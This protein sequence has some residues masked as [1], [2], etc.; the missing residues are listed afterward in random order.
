MTGSTNLEFVK[1]LACMAWA[2]TEVTHDEL[3][4]IKR[5]AR[6][7]DLSGDEWNELRMY[8]EEPVDAREMQRVTRRFLA[9]VRGSKHKRALLQAVEQL[10]RSKAEF[11]DR[12][13]EWLGDLK[14]I[15]AESGGGAFLVDGLKSLLRIGAGGSSLEDQGREADLHEFIHDRV[16]F[17]LRR[18]VGAERLE[19]EGSP[20][21]IKKLSLSASLLAHVGYVDESFVP[22]E[23][24]LLKKLLREIWGASSA[25]AE[26]IAHTAVAAVRKGFDL[27]RLVQEVKANMSAPQRR[28]LVE[29]MFALARAEGKA[30]HLEIEE[31]RKVAIS[32]DFTHKEFI[33]SKIDGL[34]SSS[35]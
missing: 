6:G 3:N 8:L 23:E 34:R 24:T 4:F 13:R 35:T 32:L 17:K 25:L 33:E 30:A 10:L 20:E 11:S 31:I 7:F 27:H 18:S 15:V 16:L 26:A 21:K 19:S 1:V 2:D 9:R 12:E 22:E 28:L 29:A 5:F 14:E